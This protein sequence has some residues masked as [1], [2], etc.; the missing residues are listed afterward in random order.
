[1]SSIR[2]VLAVAV[3]A[4]M[5]I[6]PVM[7]VELAL[8]RP[9]LAAAAHTYDADA[10]CSG[11]AKRGL[12][13]PARPVPDALRRGAL[14]AIDGAMVTEKDTVSTGPV[15]I[16]RYILG[17]RTDGGAGSVATLAGG[18]A[19]ELWNATQAG[20]R[21]SVQTAGGRVALVVDGSRSFPTDSNAE[22]VAHYNALS[23]WITVVLS[24][25]ELL[26]LAIVIALRRR[27]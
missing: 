16:T 10:A 21:V 12:P 19:A 14:C 25:L 9:P 7:A 20:G 15:G 17:L 13:S 26:T 18:R 8:A 5:L 6:A 2:L 22:S 4:I 27:T 11:Q 1:M 24:T 23:L 3:T